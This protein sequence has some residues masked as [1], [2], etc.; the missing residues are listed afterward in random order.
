MTLYVGPSNIYQLD[1][2][3]LT[4]NNTINLNDERRLQTIGIIEANATIATK[5]WIGDYSV[6]QNLQIDPQTIYIVSG[7]ENI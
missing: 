7:D 5:I 1:T 3:V 4:D 2:A 6:Y